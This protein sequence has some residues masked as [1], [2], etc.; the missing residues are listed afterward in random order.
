MDILQAERRKVGPLQDKQ[1]FKEF[2]FF[3]T[4]F[5]EILPYRKLF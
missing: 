1:G 5:A 3:A 4:T 2:I